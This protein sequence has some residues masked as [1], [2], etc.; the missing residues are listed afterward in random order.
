MPQVWNTC[1]FNCSVRFIAFITNKLK[2]H[3]H[4]DAHKLPANVAHPDV[5]HHGP[6]CSSGQ[7]LGDTQHHPALPRSSSALG[8]TSFQSRFPAARPAQSLPLEGAAVPSPFPQAKISAQGE[9]PAHRHSQSDTARPGGV[10]SPLGGSLASA[11]DAGD[12][13]ECVMSA[14]WR[15]GSQAK[16]KI[17][18]GKQRNVQSAA[19][20]A[21]PSHAMHTKRAAGPTGSSC[22]DLQPPTAPR[23]R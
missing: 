4:E 18:K 9:P 17:A 11:E 16:K 22:P 1:C 7:T 20:F 15:R 8:F 5:H 14:R 3:L 13:Q 21:A 2:A 6:Q 12:A 10:Q 23:R 19:P